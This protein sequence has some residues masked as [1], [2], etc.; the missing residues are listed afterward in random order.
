MGLR[1]AQRFDID[2]FAGDGL[3]HI[4]AG[5]EHV[6]E[7]ARHDD[8]VGEAGRVDGAA[9]ARA[10]HDADL[11]DDAAGLRVAPEEFA[12]GGQR[13]DAFLNARA[14]RVVEADDGHA[15]VQ[16]HVHEFGDLLPLHF[17]ERS[18]EHGEVLRVH[19]HFATVDLAEADDDAVAGMS[20]AAS[21]PKSLW[22]C[23]M[24]GSISWNVPSSSRQARRSRA[25]RLPLA[26]CASMR[27]APP[28]C[29]ICSRC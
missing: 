7:A 12:V 25:V 17:R 6:A 19:G 23:A 3:D 18:A 27:A 9:R 8:E 22:R 29:S 20:A 11:R 4:R 10:E 28:P 1:A 15:A 5:D 2:V 13:V 21:M 16:R 26:C 24:Y 14:D